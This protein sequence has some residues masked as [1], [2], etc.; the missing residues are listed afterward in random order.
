MDWGIVITG[1]VIGAII[2]V[3]WVI[4]DAKRKKDKE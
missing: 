3:V 2:G 1:A 4:I